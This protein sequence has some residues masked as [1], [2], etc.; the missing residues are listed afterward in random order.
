MEALHNVPTSPL[1]AERGE[2]AK[3]KYTRVGQPT[4]VINIPGALLKLETLAKLSGESIATLYRAVKRG[5]LVVS[6]RGARCTRVTS[7]NAK[8]YLQRLAGTPV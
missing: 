7:E 8:A 3:R 4:D 2:V 6:K 5:D 1:A